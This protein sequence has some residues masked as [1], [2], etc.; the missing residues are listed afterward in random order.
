MRSVLLI[1]F[2]VILT[3]NIT[4]QQRY[5]PK[6]FHPFSNKFV[7]SADGGITYSRTDF[8]KNGIDF[9]TRASLGYYFSTLSPATFGFE[10][11][12]TAGYITGEG[13]ASSSL[14]TANYRTLIYS[15]GAGSSFNYALGK[16]F[17][18]YLFGGIS[19]F[20][21][22]PKD[23]NGSALI[24][25]IQ[26]FSPHKMMLTGE[27]GTKILFSDYLGMKLAAGVNYINS[28]LL[29]GYQLGT[30]KDIY[31]HALAGLTFYFGGIKD[32]DGDGVRDEY[33]L[34]PDTPPFVI[35]DEFGCPVDSDKDGVPDYLDECPNTPVNIPVNEKGCPVDSD[36]DGVPDYKDLCP[37]TPKGVKVDDRGCPEDSDGDG[38]P[39][40]KDLCPN[41][42]VGTEVN[43]WG[44]PIDEKVYEPIKK[45]EFILSGAVNFETGKANL[46]NSA[47][48]ELQ[49]VLKVMIDYPDTK[50]KIE[51]HTDNTGR[52][53]KNLELSKQR[54]ES[55]YNYF[56][57]N[58]I[59]NSRLFTAGYSSDYPIADNNTETGRA[60]N[61]RVAIVLIDNKEGSFDNTDIKPSDKQKQADFTSSRVYNPSVERNVGKMVFTDGYLY[62]Y[63][64]SSFRNKIKAESESS[65]LKT[66][67]FNSF[68][69]IANSPD[70]DGTWYRVRVGY[71][72]TLEEAL[73]NRSLLIKN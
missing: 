60:L 46:L 73:K 30:D 62:C 6:I 23:K 36:Q 52:Y 11:T 47:Y 50:W 15:F 42:P 51:G 18:P 41:T 32:T 40:Y 56:I 2:F 59:D 4:P 55:V 64:V 12:G 37:D 22:E 35:V 54:A 33:D 48:S 31:F 34:C 27:F 44:C 38:V 24:P 72:N 29:D 28:D 13:G 66:K 5:E 39:D 26:S 68:V 63:Q 20:Y 21:F 7:L 70:L 67:G 61:R 25:S 17:I 1:I 19:Y 43:K 45:T 16:S 58:G 57:A 53:N 49:K 9:L 71:F 65:E 3:L 8:K 69:V 14:P 10:I